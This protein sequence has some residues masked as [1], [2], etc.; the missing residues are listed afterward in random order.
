MNINDAVFNESENAEQREQ[1]EQTVRNSYYLSVEYAEFVAKATP[2][3]IRK[4]ALYCLASADL[5]GD[6]IE[7]RLIQT[8]IDFLNFTA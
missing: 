8:L 3:V 6:T 1:W 2:D 7:S 5:L 4:V